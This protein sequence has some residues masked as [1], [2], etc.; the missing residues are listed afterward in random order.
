MAVQNIPVV[1][2]RDWETGGAARER[3]VGSVGDSLAE[4]GFFAVKNHGIPDELT[5]RAY[6]VAR[7]FFHLPAEVKARY[8]DAAKQ[9]QRGFTG[10]GTEHAKDSQAPDLKEFWQ[11]GRPDVPDDHPVHRLFGPNFWP[12]EL[13]DFGPALVE[14][15]R[16]L[17]RLGGLLL[18]ACAA[19][20][21]EPAERFR[22][23]TT[24]SDTIVRV[25]YYPPIR[26]DVPPGAV[27]SAAHE[28]I[29][30]ITLLSGAT[31]EGLELK[32]HD[33]T[34]MP[35]HTGFDTIVVDSGDMLQN[36]T[37]GLYRSTT[38]RVVNPGDATSERFSMPCFVHA[39][40]DVDLAPLPSCIARTGGT[41]R[42]PAITAGEYLAQRLRE[43]GLG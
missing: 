23:M 8:H 6:E 25:L 18:E 35:V 12:A 42:Y 30:L 10:F 32:R 24:D 13:P 2:L 29:N 16:R 22:A 19:H 27:R 14:L 28:D 40:A 7:A 38:H 37:N 33:G 5:Q 21:G 31:S 17:D 1:D 34:W 4:I 43:I 39:R 20:L 15:Y 26:A 9:G 3:F 36:L 11:V 41:P